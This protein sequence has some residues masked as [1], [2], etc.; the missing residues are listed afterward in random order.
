[1]PI[2]KPPGGMKMGIDS[3]ELIL[4]GFWSFYFIL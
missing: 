4:D 2:P 3:D 1:M